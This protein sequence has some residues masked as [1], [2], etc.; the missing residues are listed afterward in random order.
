MSS[1]LKLAFLVAAKFAGMFRLAEIVTSRQ[2]RIICYHGASHSDEHLFRPTLFMSRETFARRMEWIQS[3]GFA[4][5]RLDDAMRLLDTRS[6]PRGPMVITF[7]DGWSGSFQFMLPVIRQHGFPAT[8]YVATRPLE[9]E[10]PIRHILVDYLLWRA[11]DRELDM[12]TVDRQLSGHYVL[13]SASERERA[14]ACLNSALRSK[15]SDGERRAL[16][17]RL[18]RS[19]EQEAHLAQH[20]RLARLMTMDELAVAKNYGVD[21]QLHS[22]S[23]RMPVGNAAELRREIE[24]NRAAL[25]PI[26]PGSLEHFCYPSGVFDPTAL[27]VLAELGIKSATTCEV[28]LCDERTPRLLLP[29]FLDSEEIPQI[30]F[31]AELSGFL[32]IARRCR[33]LLLHQSKTQ[34]RLER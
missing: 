29:R 10:G 8:L 12:A 25:A 22:H 18:A 30:V 28:G 24:S 3:R 32:D 1:R 21:V 15:A 23:H 16:L 33:R 34:S 4:V 26:E 13:T 11:R 14:A 20:P 6:L 2:L 19:L 27:S 31:E 9:Q 5:L 17:A 7:D